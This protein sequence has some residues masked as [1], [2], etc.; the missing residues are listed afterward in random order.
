MNKTT[1]TILG[2]ACAAAVF[3]ANARADTVFIEAE[4]FTPSSAGW[5]V[6]TGPSQRQTSG[7]AALN[8]S[9][10]PRDAVATTTVT[11][12]E[13]GYYRV[14]V[15]FASYERWRGPFRVAVL[16]G[17][18]ELG[19]EVFDTAPAA[20]SKRDHSV[21]KSFEADLPAGEV[22][23]KLSKHQ[24]Q[25]CSGYARSVDCLLLTTDAKLVP[26]HLRY[27]TQT[28]LR[29]T[30][31]DGYERPLY[32]HIF[33]DHYHA[34]WYQHYSLARDGAKAGIAP[35]KVNLLKSGEQTPWCNISPMLYQDSGAILN[36]SA[37]YGY[38]DRAERL[39]ATFE[40]AT[41]PDPKAVVRTIRADLQPNGLVVLAPPNLTTP[42]NLARLKIDR[43]V[44]EEIGKLADAHA[45]PTY[46]KKPERFPFFV[47]AQ[48][49][50]RAMALDAAV[51]AREEKTLNYF[52]FMPKHNREIRGV[53]FMHNSSYCQPDIEK[54]KARA[55]AQVEEFKKDGGSVKDIVFC[56][57]T[58]E[59]GGQKLDFIV[60]DPAYAA[61]FRAWL[62]A[63]GKTPADLLVSNWDAVRPVTEAESDKFPALYYFTQRFR[64]RALGDFIATQRKVL[65]QAYRGSFPVLANFSDGAIYQANF[66][67]QG[68]D[69]FELLN[70]P[71]QNAIWGEDWANLSSTY[72]CASYNVD[73]MR[74][75]ARAR[76]QKIGHHLVAYAGRK[77]W[78]IKL[79]ATSELAR[80]VKILNNFHYGPSWSG[81]EGGIWW[82]SS[83]WYARPEKWTANAELTREV[84]A[85]EDM[86][87]PAMPAP[88]KVAILYSSATDVWTVDGNLAPGFD[89]MHTWLALAHAQV[90]V[91][92]VSEQQAADGMLDGYQVCYLSGP[93]LTVAAA[94]KLKQW[95]QRGGTLWLTAGAAA[96][97]EYNR[98]LPTLDDL[99]PAERKDA[100]ELQ[101]FKNSG[102][103]LSVLAAKD[104]VRW[105]GGT[106]EVL[107]VKQTLAPRAGAK[108]LAT[109][110]DGSPALVRGGSV[111]CVGFLPALAYIKPAL[112]ARKKLEEENKDA[113]LLQRSHNPWEFPAHVRELLLTPV[114]AAGVEPPVLC[115]VPLVDAVYMTCDQG[116][117]IPLANYTLKPLEKLTLKVKVPRPVKRAES[118]RRGALKFERSAD[119]RVTIALPL[120]N[121]D[122]VK[123]CLE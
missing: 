12:K 53:W 34:P 40:F 26:N 16:Q 118:V 75:A 48:L 10:G 28:Y 115:D 32:I 107:S 85:V 98:P 24:N 97:D 13:A 111:Y 17:G 36:I 93:N 78:D 91:D 45:W 46:G 90:P 57:L 5:K 44:A 19:G 14:W 100:Q 96:R 83:A 113:E 79:K 110:K 42:E 11:L 114:R 21:W 35:G 72:Q 94:Q 92:I 64:T 102:R 39:R 52:G 41:A 23:L 109:F 63:M 51:T 99:L 6:V 49:D 71:D 18:R 47:S 117:L 62:K 8:G 37:R 86:L 80:G 87:L 67:A 65:E 29:V 106:A 122:F 121:N 38:T 33:A 68:V 59:P 73:L 119:G 70:S 56:E 81:H 112:V 3:L 108:V 22:T 25:N 30:I 104:E 88:A 74:A 55:A 20:K 101:S 2:C 84:G 9:S 7:L 1:L 82:K 95:V 54:M 69:Y 31:G 116:V 103:Y 120:D 89:R 43:E 4:A 58:D 27:G 66:Y 60:K 50:R 77:P 61:Q 76:G 15:R 123:L 105:D